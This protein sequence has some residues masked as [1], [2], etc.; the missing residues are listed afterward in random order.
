[1]LFSL[2]STVGF[3]QATLFKFSP[4][5]DEKDLQSVQID[6]IPDSTF[7]LSINNC[8]LDSI[9]R[10]KIAYFKTVF[11]VRRESFKNITINFQ[12]NRQSDYIRITGNLPISFIGNN[13]LVGT[14][15][16]DDFRLF[17]YNYSDKSIDNYFNKTNARHFLPKYEYFDMLINTPTWFYVIRNGTLEEVSS[18]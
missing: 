4:T 1:M 17:V 10:T 9:I 5:I 15:I 18:E 6:N 7:V 8:I 2:C 12:S 13:K 11:K 16:M 14:M 3:P